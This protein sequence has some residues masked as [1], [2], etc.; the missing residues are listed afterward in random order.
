MPVLMKSV[1]TR[2]SLLAQKS[3]SIGRAHA[4]GVPCG[5]DVPEVARGDADVDRLAGFD[6][7][8]RNQLGVARD[9]IHDLGQ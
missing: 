5:E 9:V 4:L 8:L 7:A 1:S 6:L 3:I 2:F